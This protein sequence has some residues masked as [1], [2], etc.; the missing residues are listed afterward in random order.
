MPVRPYKSKDQLFKHHHTVWLNDSQEADFQKQLVKSNLKKSDFLRAL[1]IHGF[2]Q[3]V[4]RQEER[5]QY[6]E[7]FKL[8]LEYKTHFARISG[9]IKS[10]DQ[11]LF[12]AVKTL[13][14]S[15][16]RHLDSLTRL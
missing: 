8:L 1:V 13:V 11:S 14:D 4:P 9:L 12:S 10:K 16:G 15:I 7:L 2:V 3:A 5:K 6:I